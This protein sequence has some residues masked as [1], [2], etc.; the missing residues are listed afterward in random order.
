V[1][2]VVVLTY[3]API[4]YCIWYTVAPTEEFQDAETCPYP[5]L[6][7]FN[8]LNACGWRADPAA[9]S[10]CTVV[11]PLAFVAVTPTF[12]WAPAKDPAKYKV[13]DV[14]PETVVQDPPFSL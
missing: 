9:G 11:D 3:P 14:P 8:P 7:A 10:I 4:E 13:D 2:V 12:I 5:V 1:L 6:L